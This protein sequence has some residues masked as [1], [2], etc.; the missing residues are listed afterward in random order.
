MTV[1]T[2]K[3]P[4]NPRNG[5]SKRGRQL[6][7]TLQWLGFSVWD[8]RNQEIWLTVWGVGVVLGL[9]GQFERLQLLSFFFISCKPRVE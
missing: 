6:L 8:F 7:Q 1:I 9:K 4:G 5:M 3:E 2:F